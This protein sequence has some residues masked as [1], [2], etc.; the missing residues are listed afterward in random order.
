MTMTCLY[1]RSDMAHQVLRLLLLLL[2][3]LRP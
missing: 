1:R 2:L 3:L